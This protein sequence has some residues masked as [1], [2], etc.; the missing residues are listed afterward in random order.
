MALV[1]I[2]IERPT[3]IPE[4]QLHK[5]EALHVASRHRYPIRRKRYLIGLTILAIVVLSTLVV[6]R[7]TVWHYSVLNPFTSQIEA[8]VQFP[9]YHP[10]SLPSG[11]S[12]DP[13]SVNEPSSGV[14]VFSID[15]PNKEKIFLSEESRPEKINIEESFFTEFSNLKESTITGG[16]LATGTLN[17]GRTE[18]ASMLNN[19]VWIIATT[20]AHI[21]ADQL[22][23]ILKSL[24]L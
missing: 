5:K 9:L 12:V 4:D 22:V 18:V 2:T 24:S 16:T 3:K 15:G 19:Q 1:N 8:S 17:Q 11:F 21:P 6:L 14:V 20:A 23:A 10:T 13:K 7:V